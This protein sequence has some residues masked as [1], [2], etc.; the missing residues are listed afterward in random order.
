MGEWLQNVTQAFIS[1]TVKTVKMPVRLQ[2]YNMHFHC[3]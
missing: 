2:G 3:Y 1:N